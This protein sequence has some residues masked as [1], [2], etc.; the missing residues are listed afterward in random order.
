MPNSGA[1]R[2][3]EE[4]GAEKIITIKKEIIVCVK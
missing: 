3:N 2:L 1:K 4:L